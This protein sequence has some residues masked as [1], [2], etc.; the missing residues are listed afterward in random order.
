MLSN[1]ILNLKAELETATG[2]DNIPTIGLTKEQLQKLSTGPL[3]GLIYYSEEDNCYCGLG[4]Y[5]KEV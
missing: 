5:W 3:S 1:T 2:I 4:F